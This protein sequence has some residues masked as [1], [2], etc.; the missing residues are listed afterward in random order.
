M[1]PAAGAAH[2]GASKGSRLATWILVAA[3]AGVA[4]GWAAH[5]F[6][7]DAATAATVAGYFSILSDV[8]LRLIKMIIAPLVFATVVAGITGMG[9]AKAVGRIGGKALGWFITASLVSLLLGMFFANLFHPGLDLGLPL[10]EKD[11]A[12]NLKTGGLG[13]REFIAHVFPASFF[14]AMATNEILQIL[15]F[16]CFFGFA[17][18]SLKTEPAKTVTA[19][20][21]DLVPVMLK[22]TDFVMWFA[23]AGVF[24]AVAAAITVQ[25]LGILVT[26]GKFIGSFYVALLVLWAVLIGAGFVFLGPRVFHLMG[27]VKEP[28]LVA[29]TTAS[30]EAAYPKL[31]EKLHRFG[32]NDRVTSFVLPLGYSFNLDGSMV[33]QSF[34]ALFIAQAY[35]IE[36]SFGQQLTLLLVMMVSSKGV[37]GVPRASLV[38]VAAVLPTFGLPEA[39]LLLIMGID[40]FLDMGRTATNV[41]GNSIATSVVAKW[42]GQLGEPVS[43]APGRG[44]LGER[45]LIRSKTVD[46][47]MPPTISPAASIRAWACA[48]V[49]AVAALLPVGDA[50]AQIDEP[51]ALTLT[52]ALKRIKASGVVRI[53]YRAQALPFSYEAHAGQPWGYSIDLCEAIVEDIAREIGVASLRT[54][55]RRVTPSDR[56]EQVADG[57]IDLECGASTNTAQRRTR[58]AFS[59]LTFVSGTRLLVQRGGP[60]HSLRDLAGRRVVVVRSTTNA[61]VIHQLAARAAPAFSVLEVDD[62]AQALDRLATGQA[63]ALAAD[64]ILITAYLA[65][66]GLQ[67]RYAVVGELLSY[68]P[69]GIMFARDDASLAAVVDAS[70]RRLAVTREIRWIYDKWFMRR[71]PS[72]V[73]I[74]IPMSLQLE[75][76]FQV[77]GLPPD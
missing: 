38:V 56:I 65:E 67:R 69:Y 33:Y 44:C 1:E 21:S 25:G 20:I 15:V 32:V 23:P 45:H 46:T 41:I 39:G 73:R 74:G 47:L 24:G 64:D 76:S 57:R 3:A 12:T 14:Q 35:G 42:E 66:H 58:V 28:L 5:E 19:F 60:V 68:E 29:F 54:E 70:F 55:Y 10:P 2:G 71:L 13:L 48:S 63:E 11:M 26:Y 8:F 51:P 52:G 36:M 50:G 7:P 34:A 6:S 72:G 59:P 18:A 17:I 16:S 4:A 49:V 61:E 77:L 30:S 62:H 27:L 75:R 22:V 9:D 53:G 31:M 43:E 37:A 40:Q